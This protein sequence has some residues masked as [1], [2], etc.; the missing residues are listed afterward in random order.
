VDGDLV[1]SRALT[2]AQARC[3]RQP[4]PARPPA[5]GQLMPGLQ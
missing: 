5:L 3:H 2:L 4:D 1:F